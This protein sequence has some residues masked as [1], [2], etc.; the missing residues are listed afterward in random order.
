M[1]KYLKYV[2][3][4]HEKINEICPINSIGFDESDPPKVH[5][6]FKPEATKE[7]MQKAHNL[8][9]TFDWTQNVD[10]QSSEQNRDLAITRVTKDY[11]AK[12]PDLAMGID[13]TKL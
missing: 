6:S 3:F 13:V 4:L 7:Q 8:V 2:S 11:L 12:N 10:L 9:D 1:D 5:I